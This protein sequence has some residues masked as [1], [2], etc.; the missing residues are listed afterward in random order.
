MA[1][2][3]AL[4]VLSAAR[5]LFLSRVSGTWGNL[6]DGGLAEVAGFGV[7]AFVGAGFAL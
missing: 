3:T 1:L 6:F 4:A 5:F 2:R 7:A